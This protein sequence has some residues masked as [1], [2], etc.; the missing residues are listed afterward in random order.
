MNGALHEV[1]ARA[2]SLFGELALISSESDWMHEAQK[3]Y[4]RESP[5]G[6]STSCS[7]GH[8]FLQSE[9]VSV[10]SSSCDSGRRTMMPKP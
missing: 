3:K 2:E 9:H 1:Q 10:E 5:T 8:R 4:N 7:F 6:R